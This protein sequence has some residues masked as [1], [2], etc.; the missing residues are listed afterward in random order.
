[1]IRRASLRTRFAVAALAC[2]LPLLGVVFYVVL[3]TLEYSRDQLS[4]TE[5]AVADLVAQTVV[6]TLQDYE[7]ILVDAAR[8]EAVQR[9]DSVGSEEVLDS[10]VPGRPNLKELFLFDPEGALIASTG[11]LE[12]G[13]LRPRFQTALDRAIAG[14]VGVS[15]RVGLPE[16]DVIALVAPVWQGN[17]DEGQPVG[18]I[19]LMFSAARLDA[20]LQ[21]LGGGET[22]IAVVAENGVIAPRAA[23][24]TE[25]RNLTERLADPIAVAVAGGRGSHDYR[26]DGGVQRLAVY[27]PVG[28]EDV[29]WA[30]LV[31]NPSP[32]TYG[33]N[34]TLLRNGLFVLA[35]AGVLTLGIA[36]MLGEVMARPLRLLTRQVSALAG[37]DYDQN[38]ET[39]GGGE[40]RDLS[41]A[42]QEMADRLIAQVRDLGSAREERERQA[43][44]L[45]DLHRRTL[46]LQEDE[47]RRIAAEIHDAVS[48]LIT[49]AL[50]QARALRLTN[51]ATEPAARDEALEA[52]SDHL[53]GATEELHGVIFA[54][55][56]PD[57][58]DIGVVAAIE[59]YVVGVQRSG[60]T[61]HLDV[62]GEIP[63]LAPEVRLGVYRI[64]QE[65][66]HNVL[67]HAGADEAVV[68]LE[69]LDAV[70]LRVTIRDNGAGFDPERE[71]R[72]TSLGLLS[73][74]ERAAA[75]GATLEIRA[76]PGGGTAIV[77]E[78]PLDAEL[79]GPAAGDAALEAFER[80]PPVAA[81]ESGH[82]ASDRDPGPAIRS[83]PPQLVGA[84]EAP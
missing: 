6:Q 16:G 39:V 51:G 26:E 83:T 78:R 37:G 71:V 50:Y 35:A 58:D 79:V 68:R 28:F 54:L 18:G 38:V 76:R 69:A 12:P 46:R 49:G 31:S 45:R 59:R 60:L 48:P 2:L 22:V 65:A 40:V 34:R 14:D 43:E 77:I 61:C 15:G 30:A 25:G 73:M 55:R 81:H 9:L 64:V 27:T 74:R 19:G 70:A 42:F 32:T 80:E 4:Q 7:G 82:G 21:P 56:P 84:A 8:A 57:L 53:E 23:A 33:P 41:I 63:D 66:L 29:G 11:G 36:L 52:I 17:K 62:V 20:A 1:M 67:R 10:F 24:E 47:R 72:P 44:Q 5:V 75:I 3:R 13:V